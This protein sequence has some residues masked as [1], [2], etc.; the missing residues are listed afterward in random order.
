MR[1]R[2][3]GSVLGGA[4]EPW[5]DEVSRRATPTAALDDYMWRDRSRV[6]SQ[7]DCHVP[8]VESWTGVDSATQTSGCIVLWS[9]CL[10]GRVAWGERRREL[11]RGRAAAAPGA[12]RAWAP[13]G[14][15]YA[16]RSSWVYMHAETA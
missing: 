4:C 1:R 2:V 5:T 7:R 15:P 12:D 8:D 14:I 3:S 16:R 13:R 9:V 6:G 11:P 10:V